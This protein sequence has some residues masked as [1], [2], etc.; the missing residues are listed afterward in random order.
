MGGTA[1]LTYFIFAALVLTGLVAAR[2]AVRSYQRVA[3]LKKTARNREEIAKIAFHIENDENAPARL[4][5]LVSLVANN[6]L[7]ENFFDAL[8][9]RKDDPSKRHRDVNIKRKLEE[10]FGKDYGGYLFW[11]LT[12]IA[13]IIRVYDTHCRTRSVFFWKRE[14]HGGHSR[15][16]DAWTILGSSANLRDSSRGTAA[17]A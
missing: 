15:W 6:A 17:P 4:K 2:G 9:S 7:N 5:E 8:L 16:G 10:D 1:M 14:K 12:N 13:S 11:I 3:Y